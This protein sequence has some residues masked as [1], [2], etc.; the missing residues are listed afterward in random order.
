[1]TSTS[2]RGFLGLLATAGALPFLAGPARAAGAAAAGRP[3]AVATWKRG[4][5]ALRVAA[6][7][8]AEGADALDAGE[9][10]INAVELDPEDT[11]VGLG[12]YPNE[13][14]VVELDAAVMTGTPHRYGAVA[15]IRGIATPCSVA[16][17][18]MERT[19]HCLLVG[20]GARRFALDLGFPDR[21]DLLT[22]KAREA[23][24]E[25]RASRGKNDF[26]IAP[27]DDHDT[28]GY[29]ALDAKGHLAAVVSTSG[30]A[31]KIA[32][33]VGDSPIAGAGLFVD[34]DVGAAG[35][36]GVGEEVLRTAG[37]AVVVE[38][39]RRGAAPQEAVEEA[40][41]R[42]LRKSPSAARDLK[43]QVAFLAVNLAG[44]VG[45]GSLAPVPPFD[46][47]LW[48]SGMAAPTMAVGTPLA[49]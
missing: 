15:S 39:M 34:A 23:W 6:P 35:S 14:G 33:R 18:V 13:D 19:R 37:S 3:V 45:A 4:M 25:W 9:K 36:T 24:L 10:G 32:G 40:L 30:L 20:G 17:K 42:I 5:K 48:R 49:R 22:P 2:R 44:E 47:A 31:W 21:G 29:V 41:R 16:R 27:A 26:W 43:V 46:Y 38:A 1:M 11:G 8:L 28:I 12:G 7:A